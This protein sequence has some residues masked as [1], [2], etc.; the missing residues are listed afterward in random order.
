VPIPV[1]EIPGLQ[2]QLDQI[3][4]DAETELQASLHTLG[5]YNLDKKINDLK[6]ADSVDQSDK[7]RAQAHSEA[8]NRQAASAARQ[9]M[10]GA[11]GPL[12]AVGSSDGGILGFVRASKTGTPCGWCAML[13]SRGFVPTP[14]GKALYKSN[15]GSGEQSDGSIV[16]FG[17]LD[18]YHDNCQCY[19]IPIF[20]T[21]QLKSAQF[22]LNREYA[23]LW[24]QVT[25]GLGGKD[26]LKVWRRHFRQA[27]SQK[28]Q[29]AAA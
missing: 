28:T 23:A 15:Q 1:E 14:H 17:D 16:T 29:V 27:K 3:E 9:S 13:I 10:N 11:R 22:A 7:D 25:K 18:L 5:P 4:A 21:A 24:P 6:P 20:S 26:A 12:F 2:D 19:C 8:G